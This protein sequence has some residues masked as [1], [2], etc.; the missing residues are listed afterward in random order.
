M[1]TWIQ[2]LLK[3]AG[4][5]ILSLIITRGLGKRHPAKMTPF[6]FINYIVIGV[7]ASLTLA[8]V[9]QSF[10]IGM[11]ALISWSV[12]VIA[13]DFLMMKSKW[14]HDWAEGKEMVLIRHGKVMEENLAQARL[15][16]EE[17]L[18]ELRSKNIFNLADVEFAVMEVTGDINV[19]PKSDKKPVTP[20]HMG[21]MVAPQTETQTVILDGNVLDEP[22]SNLGLNQQWLNMQLEQIGVSLDNVFIGQV[23]GFGDLYVDLFDD[24]IQTPK[25]AVKQMLY[26]NIQKTQADLM[27]FALETQNRKAKEMYSRNADRLEVI[28]KKLEPYLLR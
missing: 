12:L 19:L 5:F 21:K 23:D 10:T 4:L 1:Q 22:L 3:T 18:R 11:I 16:G 24:A 20:Y 9:I 2:I 8:G 14:V 15:T 6:F 17:L 13:L 27:T 28:L 26:A 7:L 25:P